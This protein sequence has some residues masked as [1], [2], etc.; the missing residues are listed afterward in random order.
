MNKKWKIT[1]ILAVIMISFLAS[2]AMAQTPQIPAN[3]PIQEEDQATDGVSNTN[4]A[5]AGLFYEDRDN[6][7]STTGISSLTKNLIFINLFNLGYFG[8]DGGTVNGYNNTPYFDAGTGFF[9]GSNW[10]GAAFTYGVAE[11]INL[12]DSASKEVTTFPD[13]TVNTTTTTERATVI[14]HQINDWFGLNA[15]FGNKVWGVK[16]SFALNNRKAEGY[17]AVAYTSGP[18]NKITV[19]GVDF[20][21]I[22]SIA[23]QAVPTGTTNNNTTVT[24]NPPGRVVSNELQKGEVLASKI[25]DTVEFGI[26][27]DQVIPVLQPYA[28]WASAKIGFTYTDYTWNINTSNG[29]LATNNYT[30]KGYGWNYSERDKLETKEAY[31]FARDQSAAEG[32]LDIGLDAGADFKLNDIFVL[33]PELLYEIGFSLYANKY[34]GAGGSEEAIAGIGETYYGK[35]YINNGYHTALGD[36]SLSGTSYTQTEI[37]VTNAY[38][39]SRVNQ[40]LNPSVTLNAAF[41]RVNF[42]AKYSPK[43]LF[44]NRS[45]TYTTSKRQ[46]TIDKRGTDKYASYTTTETTS[47][48]SLTAERNSFQWDNTYSFGVQLWIRPDKFRL[49]FGSEFTTTVGTWTTTKWASG[50]YPST[51]T[52]K[53]TYDDGHEDATTDPVTTVNTGTVTEQQRFTSSGTVTNVKYGFGATFFLNDYVNFDFYL[54]DQAGTGNNWLGLFLPATWALQFNIRY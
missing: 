30:L 24:T 15:V 42:A 20:L 14:T 52:K 46:V 45:Q 26:H 28:P 12:L 50:N 32:Y 13:G 7:L 37:W 22:G 27:L 5:T 51:V 34:T 21:E 8:G 31:S 53:K 41:D 33:S 39:L 17:V 1:A 47:S 11:N 2:N 49:N 6:Y 29:N 36:P 54:E 19:G 44:D 35:S 4:R 43:F 38:E 10:I 3:P 48:P 9:L 40:E 25:S 18:P 23:P 16:N